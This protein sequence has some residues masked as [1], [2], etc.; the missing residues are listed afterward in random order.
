VKLRS[1]EAI[2][3][4]LNQSQVRYLIVGGLAVAAHGFGRVTFDVDLVVQLQ[5]ENVQRAILALE[6]LGYT[7]V[8]PVSAREFSDPNI[9]AVWIREK[10]MVVFGLQSPRHPDTPVDVF[11]EE[12]FDFNQEYEAALV[13]EILPGVQVR[14]VRQETL[15]RMKESAGREKDREDVRQLRSLLEHSD[16]QE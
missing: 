14:F 9:R 4:A 1:L 12:P 13:G 11:A 6:T 15:L 7:P 3:A 16:E 5:Q 2:I 8:A 10:N